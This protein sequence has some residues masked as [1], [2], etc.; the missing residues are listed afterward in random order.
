MNLRNKKESMKKFLIFAF[1]LCMVFPMF[2]CRSEVGS[3][4]NYNSNNPDST[5]R[6]IL[7]V[8]FSR[9]GENYD[10]GY[11]N[12]GNT[13]VMAGYIK[14]YT[15]GTIFEIIPATPYPEGYDDMKKVSQQETA[16][17]IRP[18]IKNQLENLDRYSVIFVGSPIWYGEPPMIMR[19]FYDTY[20]DK[21][22]GKTF[23]PFGTH[24]GS[25]VNS[26]TRLLKEYF[27]NAK[28]F[29]ALGIKGHEVN[30]SRELVGEWLQKIGITKK[31]QK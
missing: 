20:K 27:P 3:K 2:S 12:I 18:E 5:N 14:D 30:N 15:G 24:E 13:A 9:A 4:G 21:L 1:S 31:E 8:Y 6:N 23:V 29:E 25:G 26:C 7:I 28:I 17:N 11:I 16:N 19:T 10:V 22:A